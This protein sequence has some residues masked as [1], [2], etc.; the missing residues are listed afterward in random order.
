M[1]KQSTSVTREPTN[2]KALKPTVTNRK[3]KEKMF[4]GYG[5]TIVRD[6]E[7]AIQLCPQQYIV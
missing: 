1:V 7:T 3:K 2:C 5:T 6:L 4:E